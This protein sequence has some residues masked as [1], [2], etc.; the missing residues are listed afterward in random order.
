VSNSNTPGVIDP[1]NPVT[2]ANYRAVASL[3]ADG[4]WNFTETSAY[5]GNNGRAAVKAKVKVNG[6]GD[7]GADPSQLVAVT[8][9]AGAPTRDQ[10]VPLSQTFSRW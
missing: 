1:T 10:L 2:S 5:S 9:K 6:S 7:Q 3:S 4:Q 8:D